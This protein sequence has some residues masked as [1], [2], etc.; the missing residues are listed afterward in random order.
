MIRARWVL[1]A[2]RHP[3]V[4]WSLRAAATIQVT[5][6]YL[7]IVAPAASAQ[8]GASVAGAA[9]LKDSY[10]VPLASYYISMVSV[11]DQIKHMIGDIGLNPISWVPKLIE[12]TTLM[13]TYRA[14]VG[15]MLA[16]EVGAIVLI[17]TLV[18]WVLKIALSTL[19]LQWLANLG[20]GVV[21][22]VA[23]LANQ[24]HLGAI[25]FA[26]GIFCGAFLCVR[27]DVG[28]GLVVMGMAFVFA[29][30]LWT[31]FSDPME[32]LYS[33]DG[34]MAQLR[35]LGFSASDSIA[36]NG[37]VSG[38]TSQQ[39]LDKF[40]ATL[41]DNTARQ[42]VLVLNFG[43]SVDANPAC[44]A[45]WSQAVMSGLPDGPSKAMQQCGDGSAWN[46]AANLDGSNVLLGLLIVIAVCVF[47]F[48]IFSVAMLAILTGLKAWWWAIIIGPLLMV[49]MIPGK[50][51]A[52]A[53]NGLVEVVMHAFTF[54]VLVVYLGVSAQV[55]GILVGSPQI[56]RDLGGDSPLVRILLLIVGSVAAVLFL[57]YIKRWLHLPASH[58]MWHSVR[59]PISTTRENMSH[60]FQD[61]KP[62]S[63]GARS[64]FEQWK[65]RRETE[66]G[67]GLDEMFRR[68][69]THKGSV[70][71]PA[72]RKP[73][74]AA[75]KA[76]PAAEATE[77]A[78]VAASAEAVAP[79]A[80][81][82]VATVVAPE[83]AVPAAVVA[84]GA[85][86]HEKQKGQRTTQQQAGARET[87]PQ[88]SAPAQQSPV[89]V[90][91]PATPP[92]APA[93][94]RTPAPAAG[95]GPSSSAPQSAALQR[96]YGGDQGRRPR[97]S[98]QAP[99]QAGPLQREVPP[100]P[101]RGEPGSRRP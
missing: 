68:S 34:W 29:V 45:A 30:L 75:S 59:H 52:R 12:G 81:R 2:E 62:Y 32:H 90:G 60:H 87:A 54:F 6:V 18:L 39:N 1:W 14:F 23:N 98:G 41:I 71:P 74:S 83:I 4:A 53:V 84:A 42:Q 100:P 16:F 25:C 40:I 72:A 36:H 89:P 73:A 28:R 57:H 49:G 86:H 48:F 44:A 35:L 27:G 17:L 65:Q 61:F 19:W 76:A 101:D 46:Y 66:S 95:R 51:R 94:R 97:H 21:L 88:Q 24:L 96:L 63:D 10:G 13:F 79:A 3:S 67:S 78:G 9:G 33:S 56:S 69:P 82:G 37:R 20:S 70:T 77:A 55:V 5:C 22:T 15:T 26:I 43:H 31:V 91:A 38:G 7:T 85:H 80:A 11:P 50:P 47:A 8:V 99:D 64:G 92:E 58:T 93:P